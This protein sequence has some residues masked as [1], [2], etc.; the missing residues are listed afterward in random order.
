[1][2]VDDTEKST[3]SGL[4]LNFNK[5][6]RPS[7][8]SQHWPIFADFISQNGIQTYFFLFLSLKNN[9]NIEEQQNPFRAQN[10]FTSFMFYR[11]FHPKKAF[12]IDIFFFRVRFNWNDSKKM[13]VLDYHRFW[14][15][16]PPEAEQKPL[17]YWNIKKKK[18]GE[19]IT[20]NL[21]IHCH[22]HAIECCLFMQ[23][24]GF[25]FWGCLIM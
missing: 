12:A 9:V 5:H 8:Y 18:K 23:V 24:I 3:A 20:K 6:F 4:K 14:S 17:T 2:I 25:W 21:C 13:L 7:S 1:M 11:F 22:F 16:F 15:F 10:K 19:R